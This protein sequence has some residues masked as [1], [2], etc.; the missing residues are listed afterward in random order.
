MRLTMYDGSS[1]LSPP[2]FLLISRSEH[3][4]FFCHDKTFQKVQPRLIRSLV[5]IEVVVDTLQK[6]LLHLIDSFQFH[7]GDVGPGLVS[8]RVTWKKSAHN[9]L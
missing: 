1:N 9:Q 7:A 4:S 3:I 2:P 8:V 6:I 5:N